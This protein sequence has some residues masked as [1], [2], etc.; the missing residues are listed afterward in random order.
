MNK[1]NAIIFDLDGVLVSTDHFHYKAW[2]KITDQL[3]IPF[4]EEVNNLLRGVSRL[5]SLDI[6][7]DHAGLE[8]SDSEKKLL[9][10][11]KNQYY[12][13]FLQEL[14]ETNIDPDVTSTLEILKEKNCKLAIGS[15]SRNAKFILE[16]TKLKQYFD[17][18]SD[19]NNI[20]NSK[21]HPEV[22][23]KAASYLMESPE[24][25]LVVEDAYSGIEAGNEAGMITVGIGYAADADSAQFAIKK[26]SDILEVLKK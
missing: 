2:K 20:S 22:F 13:E 16:R 15:S 6:I 5:E 1:V 17:A 24:N 18:V 11:E 8:V 10:E 19:G 7:L 9:A 21:P 25:C 14:N 12:V 4:D 3:Q 23:L 26:L